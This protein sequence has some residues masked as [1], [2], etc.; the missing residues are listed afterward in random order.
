[1]QSKVI[2]SATALLI[3]LPAVLFFLTDFADLPIRRADIGL[4]F[5]VGHAADGRL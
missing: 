4:P 2:L 5:S 1:M 3:A